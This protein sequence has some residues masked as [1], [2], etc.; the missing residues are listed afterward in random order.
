MSTQV[1][2]SKNL[3]ALI[4]PTWYVAFAEGST[5]ALAEAAGFE[6]L[7]NVVSVQPN[8][9][10]EEIVH[11]G[12]YAGVKTV[13][14]VEAGDIEMTYNVRLDE[15]RHQ[16]ILRMLGGEEATAFTQSA[17]T[18]QNCDALDFSATTA[19]VGRWYP[20]KV[21][22]AYVR[23]ATTVTVATKTEGTDFFVDLKRGWIRFAAAET[24][25]L[26][27]VV[28]APAI[29]SSDAGYMKALT[30]KQ[31]VVKT[32]FARISGYDKNSDNILFYDH[33]NFS[34]EL[35]VESTPDMDGSDFHEFALSL[36]VTATPGTIYTRGNLA[37]L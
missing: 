36:T 2:P 21:S 12:A 11:R 32:G 14:K 8:F 5:L 26:T 17:L 9:E 1:N 15:L 16:N 23:D 4:K 30:P 18:T 28:T 37:T 3:N 13:D 29:T 6:D 25:S 24:T 27:P 19:V 22:G 10:A 7:G 33:V 31:D 20:L 34:A 35:R